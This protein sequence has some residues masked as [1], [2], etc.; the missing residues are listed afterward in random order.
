MFLTETESLKKIKLKLEEDEIPWKN[1]G[2]MVGLILSGRKK[3]TTSTL[4]KL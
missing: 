4:A 2:M 3:L 1:L